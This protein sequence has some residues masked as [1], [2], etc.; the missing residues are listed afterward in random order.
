[1]RPPLFI[2]LYYR[3][4]RS[5]AHPPQL[6]RKAG[7]TVPM[8]VQGVG[9]PPPPLKPRTAALGG[10]KLVRLR[11]GGVPTRGLCFAL[12]KNPGPGVT[13]AHFPFYACCRRSIDAAVF[14]PQ[15]QQIPRQ[16]DGGGITTL[17]ASRV[18]PKPC[19]A[20]GQ[21]GILCRFTRSAPLLP[22]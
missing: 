22:E 15:K 8:P 13:G 10:V 20:T 1:M 2:L 7:Q 11:R 12:P 17:G 14:A 4:G 9:M 18:L 6:G 19:A 5:P 16:R 21:E 3:T